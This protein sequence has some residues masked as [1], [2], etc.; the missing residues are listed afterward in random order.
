MDAKKLCI[1]Y[2]FLTTLLG[3]VFKVVGKATLD[4]PRVP[5]YCCPLGY[6]NVRIQKHVKSKN[7]ET[8]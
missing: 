6:R 8:V 1:V 4:A 2:I 5:T 3:S 7:R